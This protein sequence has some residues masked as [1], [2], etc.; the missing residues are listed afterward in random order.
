MIWIDNRL[1]SVGLRGMVSEYDL[2]ELSVKYEVAVTGGAAWCLDVNQQ[3]SRIAVGTEDG[4]INTFI[5]YSD[6]LLYER[7]FDKQKGRILCIKWDNTGEMIFTGSTDTVR[8]WNSVSGHAVHKMTTARKFSKRETI[9][10]CLALTDDNHVVSGDSRGV[11]S[12][13]DPMTGT[14]IESHESHTADILAIAMSSEENVVYCA[15]VDPVVRSFAKVTLKSGG[16]PQWVK[17]IERRLHAHDV[18]ALVE[19]SGKLWSAGVDGY[20]A[21]SSYPPK[22]LVKY[23][24]FLKPPCVKVCRRSRCVMLRYTNYLE[25]WRLGKPVKLTKESVISPGALHP[26]DENPMKLLELRT[27]NEE[28]IVAWAISKDSTL[29]VYSTDTHL[30]VFNFDVIEGDAMLMKNDIDV[31][32]KSV[33]KMLFS[34]NGKLFAAFSRQDGGCLL[35]IYRVEKKRF[36]K[37]GAFRVDEHGVSNVGLACF[38]PDNKYLI[39][40]DMRGLVVLYHLNESFDFQNPHFFSLPKYSCPPTA[41]AVQQG[42]L[43]LVIVYSDHKIIEYN[44]PRKQYTEFSNNLQ[45]RLPLQWLSRPYPVTNVNFDPKNENIIIFHDDTTVYVIN[46]NKELPEKQAKIPRRENGDFGDDS[47]SG[48]SSNSQHAFQVAKKYKHLVHLEWLNDEEMVAVEVNPISLT[49]KLP[50]PLK[51][52][53]FGM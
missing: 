23:P 15:G 26:L 4:Y 9:V 46:K 44:I 3:K 38:S 41:M 16:R 21:V 25:L 35:T 11:L 34:P 50:P 24:P 18:R 47:N 29:I 28:A 30:R 43:N 22:L 52:K 10:W 8:V 14:L 20:L 5:V 49:E 36:S 6:S 13:W 42:T 33:K 1:F 53:W 17:G 37:A 32:L 40:S 45:S 51:Q 27:K 31:N 48:S 2:N 12:F 19:A 39:C 7:I